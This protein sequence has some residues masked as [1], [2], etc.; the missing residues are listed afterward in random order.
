M[1]LIR[2]RFTDPQH[3]RQT[4]RAMQASGASINIQQTIQAG[5]I[6]LYTMDNDHRQRI[7]QKYK[8]TAEEIPTAKQ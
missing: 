4:L 3:A 7:E 2:Y 6:D 8:A 5:Y 1:H